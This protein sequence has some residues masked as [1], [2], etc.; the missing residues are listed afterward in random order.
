MVGW[1]HQLDGHGFR[2]TLGVGDGQGGLACCDSWGH[3]QSDMTERLN[4]TELN[5][6]VP[7]SSVHGFSQAR[8]LE[9]FPISFSGDLPIPGIK[10]CTDR[11]ILYHCHTR[12]PLQRDWKPSNGWRDQPMTFFTL[13]LN[14]FFFGHCFVLLF[15]FLKWRGCFC[16]RHPL[17][18]PFFSISPSLLGQACARPVGLCTLCLAGGASLSLSV[19]LVSGVTSVS[20]SPLPPLLCW[21]YLL[22]GCPPCTSLPSLKRQ[23]V[24]Q[25]WTSS[26]LSVTTWIWSWA[27]PGPLP[28]KR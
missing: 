15:M 18:M 25:L 4:W 5:C 26:L 14:L 19:L 10:P 16:L 17:K 9:W 11:Q 28:M 7:G 8:T 21:L 2:W 23:F 20:P 1:H 3:K 22:A 27:S 12:K 13:G 24:P 6:R